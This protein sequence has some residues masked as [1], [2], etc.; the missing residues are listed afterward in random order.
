MISRHPDRIRYPEPIVAVNKATIDMLRLKITEL[1][2][3]VPA[4]LDTMTYLELNEL[5]N[6]LQ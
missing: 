6:S 4:T 2:P 1:A 3:T 5:Y